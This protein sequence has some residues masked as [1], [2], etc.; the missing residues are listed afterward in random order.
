M[1]SKSHIESRKERD[2]NFL[3]VD[4]DTMNWGKYRC[5]KSIPA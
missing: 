3:M 1:F 4:S 5:E 2:Q